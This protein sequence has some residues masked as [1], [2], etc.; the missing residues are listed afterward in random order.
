MARMTEDTSSSIAP[1]VH[2]KLISASEAKAVLAGIEP[3]GVRFGDGYPN[4][5]TREVMARVAR[6]NG[7]DGT[8]TF[9]I[10]RSSDSRAIGGIGVWFPEG[11]ELPRV[12]YDVI[13]P[14]RGQGFATEALSVLRD[15][16]FARPEI[17]GVRADTDVGT[18]RAGRSW[19]RPA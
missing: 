11:P 18:G 2:L 4:E 13:E 9:A 5:I 6:S 15:L 3:E 7:D 12:G 19:R 8:E 17:A 16:L 1:R 14:L 10:V